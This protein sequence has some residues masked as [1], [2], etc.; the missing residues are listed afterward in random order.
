MSDIRILWNFERMG[1]TS[2]FIPLEPRLRIES[3]G[4]LG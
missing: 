4:R 1:P 2:T 3:G